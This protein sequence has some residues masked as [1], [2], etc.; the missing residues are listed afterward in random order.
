MT[1]LNLIKG[2]EDLEIEKIISS[3]ILSEDFH[4]QILILLQNSKSFFLPIIKNVLD[5]LLQEISVDDG[6][7]SYHEILEKYGF[8]LI[9]ERE[10]LLETGNFVDLEIMDHELAERI[11]MIGT[12]IRNFDSEKD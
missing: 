7:L 10:E 1:I 12:T 8:E 2:K 9:D 6:V 3:K 4:E 11:I 5:I